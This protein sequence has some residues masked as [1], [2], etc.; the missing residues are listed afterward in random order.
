MTKLQAWF[1][2]AALLVGMTSSRARAE[3]FADLARRIPADAN[4]LVLI[5]VE[6]TVASP[7]ARKQGWAAKLESAYVERPIFLPPEAKKLVMGA[8]L[9]PENGFNGDWEIAVME[10]SEPSPVRSIA[11]NEG[12]RVEEVNSVSMAF[13]PQ[14]VAF[15][16]LEGGLLAAMR[17]A[18]RQFLSRWIAF[19]RRATRPELSEYLQSSLPLVSDRVQM[20]FAID[21]TDVLSSDDVQKKLADAAWFQESKADAA[22]IAKVVSSLRGVNL[23]VAV[24]EKSQGQLQIDFLDNVA[25]LEPFA[26]Q[27]VM[28]ALGNVG[29]Q[30]DE[31]DVWSLSLTDK[32][33]RMRGDLSTDA[34][35]RLFSVIELP[36]VDLKATESASIEPAKPDES[37]VRERSLTYFKTTQVLL[38]DLRKGLKDT[39]AT[40]AWMERYARRIDELPVLNVDDLLLDYGDK[41]AE[42]L[43]IMSLSKRQ[44][45]IRAGVRASEGGGYYDGY[46]YG[47]NA[48][49]SAANR[50]QAKKEEMAVAY[51]TRVQGWQHIDD[52]TADLRRTL[53]K[54]YSVEF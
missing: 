33:I 11:R 49:D 20:L 13:T 38:K 3:E 51:D 27:L 24:G 31:L 48:Y 23:R 53:T 4:A 45:G 28:E 1:I 2:V 18:E 15:A 43:R 50:S 16:E 29:F 54:K 34:Q 22:S 10:L 6:N 41:L 14:G 21:L 32:S 30:T 47:E 52:A 5:D 35:R 37:E 40:S 25:S 7:L 17:P 44:A 9:N 46:N 26:K 19:T 39:K 36:A 12:G 8:A 42:T